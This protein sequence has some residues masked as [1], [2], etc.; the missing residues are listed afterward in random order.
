MLAFAYL[1]FGVCLNMLYASD[2]REPALLLPVSLQFKTSHWHINL[3]Q[4]ETTKN[5]W[6][7]DVAEKDQFIMQN[8]VYMFMF[9]FLLSISLY[10]NI[11]TNIT[12]S[13]TL[14]A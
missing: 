4:K 14:N 10:E 8:V 12:S 7:S 11:I 13:T 5:S 1:C 2:S 6:C 3:E 9:V